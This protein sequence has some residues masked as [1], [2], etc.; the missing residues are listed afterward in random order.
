MANDDGDDGDG[1]DD[2][3]SNNDMGP[4]SRTFGTEQKEPP[5]AEVG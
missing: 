2:D 4:A 5:A 3:D 1:D